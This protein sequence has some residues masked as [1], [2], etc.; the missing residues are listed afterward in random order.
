MLSNIHSQQIRTIAL[1]VS[2]NPL[3]HYNPSP[4]LDDFIEDD[5]RR[6]FVRA[7]NRV[8][9]SKHAAYKLAKLMMKVPGL[10][11]RAVAVN[12]KQATKV[13]SKYLSEFIPAS[14]LAEGCHYTET[15]GWTHS[16]LRLKNGSTCQ[17][18]SSDQQPIAHAGDSLD[19]VWID[20]IPP[21]EILDENLARVMDVNGAVWLTATPIG[22]PVKWLRELIEAVDSVWKEYLV[23]F[24]HS[25]CP[26]YSILQCNNWI[27]EAMSSLW[28][29]QQ[30][31]L[32][33][34]E[35][36][37][38]DRIF[39]GFDVGSILIDLPE[40]E[41]DV[42]I[43]IDH[44]E[45]SGHE[46]AVLLLWNED[47]VIVWDE[48]VSEG[49]TSVEDDVG[50]IL[51]MLKRNSLDIRSV[52]TIVGDVNSGGKAAIKGAAGYTVNDLFEEEFQRVTKMRV[53]IDTPSKGPGSVDSGHW[54]LNHALTRRKLYTTEN[55]PNLNHSL[56]HYNGGRDRHLIDALRYIAV[57]ILEDGDLESF[58]YIY[59]R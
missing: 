44:G 28:T 21:P 29:Y 55:T 41:F 30:R 33:A 12:Y 25:N 7:A 27:A 18:M 8:G 19:V 9:K 56:R 45:L 47:V 53:R 43:G 40:D 31:I 37:T 24:N 36:L 16:L 17:I 46:G 23:E 50:A 20:E 58:G 34:W 11:A 14:Y 22:R 6:I 32:G 59:R 38:V 49:R 42:G 1:R 39:S 51:K 57:P 15:R 52:D 54:V 4:A 3:L 13:I 5:H 35:G 26:W 48:Y 10:R 2:A